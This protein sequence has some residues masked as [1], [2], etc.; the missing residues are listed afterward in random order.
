MPTANGQTSGLKAV[1]F[2]LDDTLISWADGPDDWGVATRPHWTG[3]YHYLAGEG[4]ALPSLDEFIGRMR[5]EVR[6]AWQNGRETLEAPAFERILRAGLKQM[7]LN[8]ADVD[9]P[10]AMRAYNWQAMEGVAVYP[11]T[12][13]VLQTL[14]RDGYKLGLITNSHLPMWMRDP[15]LAS[16][17]LLDFFDARTTSGDA[18]YIKPH[19]A[20]YHLILD[21]LE[22]APEE[23]VF[24]GDNP[25]HDIA[26]ANEAG[27]TS[28]LIDPPHL[29]RDRDGV[30]PDFIITRLAELLPI[31]DGLANGRRP[32]APT[33]S[34]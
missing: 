7:K 25:H 31:V 30:A 3:V 11:D 29:D 15:E 24:V 20:V 13:P 26:G 19:P 33:R 23:A 28:V 12:L 2:D 5:E 9:F 1:L 4:H 17:G 6:E 21:Q 18:R 34:P 22:V 8:L 14:R 16:F 27:L 10:A 32:A